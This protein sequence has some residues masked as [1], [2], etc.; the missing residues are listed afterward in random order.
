MIKLFQSNNFFT[1]QSP[2][3]FV[4]IQKNYHPAR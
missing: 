4:E 2:G 1:Q 3:T